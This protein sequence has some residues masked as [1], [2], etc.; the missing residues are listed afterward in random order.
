MQEVSLLVGSE[1]NY[2]RSYKAEEL[3]MEIN[4]AAKPICLIGMRDEKFAQKYYFS[5]L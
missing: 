4:E 1:D 3:F 2:I 5:D